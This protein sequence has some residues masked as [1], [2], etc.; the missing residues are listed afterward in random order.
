MRR[1][2]VIASI[3]AIV[4]AMLA[5]FIVKYEVR[6]LERAL[7]ALDLEKQRH[8]EAIRVLRSEWSYLNRPARIA[9]LTARYLTL[10]PVRPWQVRQLRANAGEAFAAAALAHQG[11]TR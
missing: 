4:V 2:A 3:G 10:E 11:D 8:V 1:I 9:D 5:L 7:A 6:D